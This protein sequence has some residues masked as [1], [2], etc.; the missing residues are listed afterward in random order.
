MVSYSLFLSF[1]YIWRETKILYKS[2]PITGF[3]PR[4][5]VV[6]SNRSTNWGTTAA[7]KVKIMLYSFKAVANLINILQS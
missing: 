3:D 1:Q 5:S 4:T 2:L 6:E 7:Q